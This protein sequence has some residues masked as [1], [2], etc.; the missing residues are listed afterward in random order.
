MTPF[1]AL[2]GYKCR[3]PLCWDESAEA[4]ILGPE[5]L[6]ETTTQI[7]MIRKRMLAAQC[8]QK[9]YADG[10]R[11]NLEFQVGEKVFVKVSP[12]KGVFRFGK[13]G[14]LN[15]R[16]VGPFEILDRVGAV[17][18]RLALPPTAHPVHNVFHISLLRK[19]VSDPSHVLSY[20]DI[21][22]Q[23]TGTY[24]EEP[25]RILERRMKQLRTKEVPL[26]KVLWAKHGTEA[27]TWETEAEM[28]EKFPH[29]FTV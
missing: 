27:M 19:Y 14:K 15:P 21:E 2:Y 17:A 11:R 1:E 13:R 24:E 16:Y 5:L 28:L 18:Y 22:V 4:V 23:P 12:T 6:Q 20:E 29:L 10:K 7:Q 25:I 26:V 3:S 9:A 8:R